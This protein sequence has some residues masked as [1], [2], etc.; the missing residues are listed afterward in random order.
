V[1]GGLPLDVFAEPDLGAPPVLKAG[2]ITLDAVSGSCMRH[3]MTE[4]EKIADE[5]L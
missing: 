5:G 3:V 2:V 4:V 1:V